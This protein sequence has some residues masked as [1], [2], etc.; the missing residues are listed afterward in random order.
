M[1]RHKKEQNVIQTSRLYIVKNRD[2]GTGY[3]DVK[4]IGEKTKFEDVVPGDVAPIG[5]SE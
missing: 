3:I 1:I 5:F 2:G 4:F